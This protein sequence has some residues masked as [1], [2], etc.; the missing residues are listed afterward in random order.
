MNIE[1]IA[2]RLV[3]LSSV[4]ISSALVAGCAPG[5]APVSKAIPDKVAPTPTMWVGDPNLLS[6]PEATEAAQ[7]CDTRNLDSSNSLYTACSQ[8][9]TRTEISEIDKIEEVINS[10]FFDPKIKDIFFRMLKDEKEL[11]EKGLIKYYEFYINGPSGHSGY[12]CFKDGS[13][14]F[15]SDVIV[16]KFRVGEKDNPQDE[17]LGTR[18]HELMHVSKAYQR[19]L[20][21]EKCPYELFGLEKQSE[22]NEISYWQNYFQGASRRVGYGYL[23]ENGVSKGQDDFGIDLSEVVY[24]VLQ[25]NGIK[26]DSVLYQYLLNFDNLSKRY[27]YLSRPEWQERL[28]SEKDK[29]I[30]IIIEIKGMIKGIEDNWV[31]VYRKLSSQEKDAVS[32]IQEMGL[33]QPGF[34][35]E[36]I[37]KS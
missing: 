28:N 5:E 22:E 21:G 2:S 36:K 15:I 16:P 29:N 17:A 8:E 18:G 1:K 3:V 25:P 35:P 14:N 24:Q 34:F 4:I 27:D 30:P 31:D 11:N 32:K 37:C 13:R 19:F 12:G 23:R 6:A 7:R 33:V 9:K 20:T 10:E 26:F